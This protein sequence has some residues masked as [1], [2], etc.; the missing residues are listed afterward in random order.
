LPGRR[1]LVVTRQA[2]WQAAGAET[3]PSLQAALAAVAAST[4]ARRVFVIGGG[5]LYAQALP[6]A[7]TLELTEIDRDYTGD[8][9]FPAFDRQLFRE[10]QREAHASTAPDTPGFAFVTYRR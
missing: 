1:N 9:V 4:D 8:T 2:Q 10:V 5:E 7:H 6:L 3:Q